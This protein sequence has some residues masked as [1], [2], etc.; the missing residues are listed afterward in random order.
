[1]C[2]KL[3]AVGVDGER[4]CGG[5]PVGLNFYANFGAALPD[6]KIPLNN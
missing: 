3:D 4:G 1:M 6:G 2:L 5:W